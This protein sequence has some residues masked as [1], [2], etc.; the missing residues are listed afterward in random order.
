MGSVHSLALDALSGCNILVTG[1]TGLIGSA[2]VRLLLSLS[3]QYTVYASGRNGQQAK[4]IFAAYAHKPQ[5]RFINHDVTKEWPEG[6]DFHY[7]IHLAGGATPNALSKDP[8]GVM[9]ANFYGIDHLLRYGMQHHMKRLLYVSSSEV[10]GKGE[11]GHSFSEAD[12]GYVDSMQPRSCYPSAKRAAETLCVCYASQYGADVVVARPSYVYGGDFSEEDNRVWA[13]FIRNGKNGEDIV[14]KSAG[15]QRRSWLY[16]DDC[17][18]ALL[19]ILLKGQSGC[20]YNV[21]DEAGDYSIRELAEMVAHITGQ[22]VICGEASEAEI[23]GSAP[24]R[25][26]TLN[27]QR[28][29]SLG[30]T[31]QHRLEESFR[32]IFNR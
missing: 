1:A 19:Y 9:Q 6:E 7:I 27:A 29:R 31:A 22:K 26:A 14:L 12:C 25:Q 23:K 13:Q 3:D 4:K 8:V 17:A 18:T 10:Y 2:V 15:L 30:W 20:A 16:V 24:S 32:T 11:A 21:A 28:L 5:F